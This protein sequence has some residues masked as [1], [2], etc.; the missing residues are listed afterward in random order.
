M[1]KEN[2]AAIE[3]VRAKLVCAISQLE[4]DVGITMAYPISL[5]I[6]EAVQACD[7]ALF[8]NPGVDLMTTVCDCV[9]PTTTRCDCHATEHEFHDP[10]PEGATERI[11]ELVIALN[12]VHADYLEARKACAARD[13]V[14]NELNAIIERSLG[15]ELS[16]LRLA[17]DLAHGG[18]EHDDTHTPVEWRVFIQ[19][20]NNQGEQYATEPEIRESK[21]LAVAGLAVAAIQSSRRKRRD[22]ERDNPE[23]A[24]PKGCA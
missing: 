14:I 12:A 16:A 1:T 19:I 10:R 13:G 9:T 21:L 5:K 4:K 8:P 3:F 20:Y 24:D 18:P 15:K 11:N 6:L 7:D 22:S 17:Q 23:N 2:Q